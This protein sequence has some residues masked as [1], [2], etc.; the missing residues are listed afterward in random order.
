LKG[1]AALSLRHTPPPSL[2]F[3]AEA[4]FQEGLSWDK[5]ASP[6]LPLSS[7]LIASAKPICGLLCKD[8]FSDG[9]NPCACFPS[10]EDCSDPTVLLQLGILQEHWGELAHPSPLLSSMGH[11]TAAHHSAPPL[12][13]PQQGWQPAGYRGNSGPLARCLRTHILA[14]A[15]STAATAARQGSRPQR[16][17]PMATARPVR[18]PRHGSLCPAHLRFIPL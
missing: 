16:R 1:E 12:P 15:T 17:P 9:P 6:L 3:P 7:P 14:T 10:Q 18:A 13:S 11:R 5:V 4:G 2:L 8:G